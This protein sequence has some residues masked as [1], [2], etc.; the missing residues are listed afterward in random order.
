VVAHV[1]V[2]T[3]T[4]NSG[5]VL[6]DFLRS[7]GGQQGAEWHLFAVDNA[8]ADDT[9]AQLRAFQSQQASRVTILES[10][11]N[12]GA[13]EG[14]NQAIRAAL[15]AG[16]ELL[17]FLNNDVAFPADL[18]EQLAGG[19]QDHGCDIACP[20][21]VYG[22]RTE[23]VWA[24]GGEFQPRAGYRTVHYGMG[25]R[26][27]AAFDHPR[28]IS[29]APT[30]C[31]L[32]TRRVIERVGELDPAYFAYSED[33]D[34]MFRA[35]RAGLAAW[36]IPQARVQHKVSALA[37][38]QSPFSD[39]YGTRNRVYFLRKNIGGAR[40]AF[41]SGVYLLY[42]IARWMAR[43]DSSARFRVKAAAWREGQRMPL[44]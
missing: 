28:R 32:V 21:I 20:R 7:L 23:I 11:Q 14:N 5:A 8:S 34:F 18:L 16:F 17:L 40:A 9:L 36:Y 43:R 2:L 35:G 41:W 25:Q 15:A 24:A 29:Y 10:A 3:V 44:A 31:L 38:H 42:C 13:A 26:D 1:A 27:G 22:D 4:Y 37:G 19:L 6:P 30:T 39:R 33:A 12:L